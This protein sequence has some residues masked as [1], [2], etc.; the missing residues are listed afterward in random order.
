MKIYA[1]GAQEPLIQHLEEIQKHRSLSSWRCFTTKLDKE[2]YHDPYAQKIA[3][4]F[5]EKNYKNFD[6]C[7]FAF[8][9]L[10]TGHV[11]LLFQGRMKKAHETFKNFLDFVS[12]NALK[13]DF[14]TFDMGK[15]FD[16]VQDI[17]D[18]ALKEIEAR[19]KP[20]KEGDPEPEEKT[21]K[22]TEEKK[23]QK[24]EANRLEKLKKK[25]DL[26]V[27]PL[28]LVVEDERMTQAFIGSMLEN[29]CE[30]VLAE[31]IAEG[32]KLYKEIWPSLVF[33]DIML[34]D[35]DGQDLTE[36]LM[37]L[38]PDA[39]VIMVSAHIS[40]EKILRCKR[41]GAKGFVAKP[42]TKDK[43]RLMQQIFDYNQ[44]KKRH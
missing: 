5:I 33:M 17:F 41:A 44:Y 16:W 20:E 12:E 19:Q 38:D 35:G 15:Q 3:L 21:D 22:E 32:R 42:V 7:E 26:R 28:L 1:I 9:W 25:R 11:F 27:K 36:E 13:Q 8:Y 23:R 14:Q 30:V 10:K 24:E 4:N 34:P 43:E 39:Y 2:L 31:T 40:D 29:Y 37:T 18:E 6:V